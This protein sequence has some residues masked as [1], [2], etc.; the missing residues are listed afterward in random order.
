MLAEDQRGII[1]TTIF[2]FEDA[3]FLNARENII[4]LVDEAHRTQ[5]GRVAMTCAARSRRPVLR[6]DG[7]A[8]LGRR[9]E[10][11]QAVRRPRRPELGPE[12]VLHRALHR[13]WLIGADSRRDQTVDFHIRKE[14]LDEAFAA[15][16]DEERLTDEERELLTDRAA[17]A[18]TIVRNPDRIP[19][20]VRR[21]R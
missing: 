11:V 6:A 1:V 8:Y 18:R 17:Q 3:G 5:E 12:Q 2:R 7:D 10:H 14:A 19:E 20:S 13:G 9:A 16:A 21:H 15:M 4:V